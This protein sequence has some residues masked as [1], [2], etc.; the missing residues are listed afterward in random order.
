[1]KNFQ[2]QNNKRSNA[3]SSSLNRRGYGYLY[4][5]FIAVLII[6]LL[7]LISTAYAGE[8]SFG[9]LV[10][11]LNSV[12]IVYFDYG[13][14]ELKPEAYRLLDDLSLEMKSDLAHTLYITGYTDDQG[15][16]NFNDDLSL[17]RANSVKQYLISTGIPAEN[18]VV[19]GR[20]ENEPAIDNSTEENR[21]KNR[22]VVFSFSN[23][24]VKNG[25][26]AIDKF[27]GLRFYAEATLK[28]QYANSIF[29]VNSREEI[30]ADL[31]LRDSA[32]QPVDSLKA[33]DIAAMLRWETSGVVDS[34]EGQPRLIPINDKK[35]VAFTLTMDYSGSM[36]GDDTGNRKLNPTEKV[37]AMEGSVKLFIDLLGNNMFGKIIKFGSQVLASLRFTKS[38]S[39]LYGELQKNSMPLGGTALY[40]SIY[41]GLMDTTYQSNPTVVKTVIAFTDGMENSS[42]NITLDSIYRRSSLSN[43]KVFTV[44]LFSDVG[45]YRPTLPELS[46]R[47]ADMLSI[48]QN[49]GGFFYQANSPEDLKQI[50]ANILD[51]VLKSYFVSIVWNSSKLPPKGTLVKAELKINVKGTTRVLYKNYIME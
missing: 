40:R 12:N 17:K 46:R 26:N 31:S 7:T 33:E 18:L 22:R 16:E 50:Y 13:K 49:T 10:D 38:K 11:S 2:E 25:K 29:R 14:S 19:S 36:Y 41:N 8:S 1:M 42:G 30:T 6:S 15:S 32:G 44:G 45:S 21:A 39:V 34:T 3:Q 43:T 51:Q 20:G 47:K 28:N 35:K 24:A 4:I 23:S 5:L 9:A 48:A 27:P 37:L